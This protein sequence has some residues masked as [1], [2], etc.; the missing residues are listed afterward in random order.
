MV[1]GAM[2]FTFDHE[3]IHFRVSP[4]GD[5]LAVDR[6]C[7]GDAHHGPHWARLPELRPDAPAAVEMARRSVA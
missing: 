7:D 6:W 4:H 2:T 3:G 5:G 1:V